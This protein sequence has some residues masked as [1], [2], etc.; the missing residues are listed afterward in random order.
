M[1]VAR[2]LEAVVRRMAAEGE[3]AKAL[4]ALIQRSKLATTGSTTDLYR[5]ET[6]PIALAW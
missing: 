6:A 5:P 4:S 3:D 1:A 2:E